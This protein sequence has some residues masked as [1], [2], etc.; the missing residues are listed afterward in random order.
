MVVDF[1]RPR[2]PRIEGAVLSATVE[3]LAETGYAGLLVS[4]IAERAGTS[5][6]AIY[7]RWPSK[8]HLVHEAVFPIGSATELPDTG[9]LP[10]DLREMVS[11][12]M[13]FLTTPAARAALPGL[14]GEMAADPTLHSALLER[15]AGV[16]GGGLT[17]L[18]GRAAARG[19][20]RSDVTA[21]ELTDAIAGITLMGLLTRVTALDSGLGEA[22]VDRTT[23]LLLKGISA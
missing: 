13:V 12:S 4:A 14:V 2:D 15:F 1:G 7:R 21:A 17:E 18:L 23:T 3:L 22:W 10:D 19:E 8:A 11:R 9:S 5:K 16:I 6:P 20:V